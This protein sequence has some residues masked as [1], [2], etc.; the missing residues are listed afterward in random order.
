MAERRRRCTQKRCGKGERAHFHAPGRTENPPLCNPGERPL[1]TVAD[2]EQLTHYRAVL[3]LFLAVAAHALQPAARLERRVHRDVAYRTVGGWNGTLDIHLPAGEARARP[4][5]IYFHGGGWS[6]GNRASAVAHLEPYL[7][8]GFAV[9]NV[10]YR[11]AA[12]APAPAAASDARCAV[13]WIIRNASAYGMDAERVVLSGHSA[14]GHLALIAAYAPRGSL[15]DECDDSGGRP[16]AVVAWNAPSDLLEYI[17]RRRED[18]DPIAWLEDAKDPLAAARHLSPVRHVRPDLPATISLHAAADPEVP[19]SHATCLHRALA[20]AGV[21]QELV[22]MQSSGH[23]TKDHPAA[24]VERAY[25]QI[26]RFL[27]PLRRNEPR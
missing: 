26:W 6:G 22:T 23:L 16:A 12:R 18:G 10:S 20:R 8:R 3:D 27:R 15:G 7:A 13:H 2:I 5:L 25:R 9:V 19:H 11:L 24:E 4:V 14:G 21:R 17:N 1:S